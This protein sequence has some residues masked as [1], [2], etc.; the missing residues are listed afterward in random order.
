MIVHVHQLE[1]HVIVEEDLLLM[2]G[3]DDLVLM[4]EVDVLLLM[5]GVDDLLLMIGDYHQFLLH[6]VVMEWQY[7]IKKVLN[8][9]LS[10]NVWSEFLE[11]YIC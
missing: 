1:V 6:L 9:L 11:F 8:I 4:I 5:I 3:V 2:I 7:H 10:M